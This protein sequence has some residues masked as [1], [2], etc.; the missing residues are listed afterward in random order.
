MGVF[1]FCMRKGF[2]VLLFVGFLG[3]AHGG[4]GEMSTNIPTAQQGDVLVRITPQIARVIVDHFGEEIEVEREQ[5][6]E[7]V[8]DEDWA[9]TSRP[10]PPFCVMPISA[11]PGVRTV[12][13]LE[14]LSF[15]TTKVKQN[16]GIL[17]DSRM[18]SWYEIETI[19]GS[20][21]LP[22]V[23]F[24]QQS[25]QRDLI[26][27]MLGGKKQG[28]GSWRFVNPPELMFYCNG[29][30]CSQSPRAIRSLVKLGYPADRLYYYRGGM[31]MWKLLGMTTVIPSVN[32][33]GE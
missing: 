22:F 19:P 15:V 24:T 12:G 27:N 28:D 14:L 32:L 2:G 8:V 9:K 33:V 7:N 3:A 18:P 30:W 1:D 17:V 29:P 23:I 4:V 20:V 10:C 25:P 16:K 31:Q 11:A 6:P 5:D 26:L 21:N 13:E